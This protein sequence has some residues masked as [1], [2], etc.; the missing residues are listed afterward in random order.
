[1]DSTETGRF[2]AM[3]RSRILAG[4]LADGA[5]LDSERELALSYGLSRTTIRA[6]LQALEA[7]GLI[8]RKVGRSGGSFVTMPGSDAVTSSLQLVVGSGG[9]AD[10]DL[11]EARIAVEPMCAELAAVR[12]GAGALEALLSIQTEMAGLVHVVGNPV[13]RQRFLS[14]NAR[15]HLGIAVG[16]GNAV[17]AAVLKGLIEP[18]EDLTDDPAVVGE[19]QLRETIRA[20]EAICSALIDRD[21]RRASDS[22]RTHLAAHLQLSVG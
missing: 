18:I 7:S 22:M 2:V 5:R 1:M 13:D 6:A 17:L 14:A 3:M 10:V 19:P 15:F 8:E 12:M 9:L 20:H 21:K 4:E 11:M 16:S